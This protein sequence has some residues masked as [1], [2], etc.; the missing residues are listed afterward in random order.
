MPS[1]C[2]CISWGQASLHWVQLWF[3]VVVSMCCE[4]CFFGDGWQPHPSG[5]AGLHIKG[6]W[7]ELELRVCR[8]SLVGGRPKG[9]SLYVFVCAHGILKKWIT[10][11]RSYRLPWA[12]Q[13][14]CYEPISGPRDEQKGLCSV[15]GTDIR[16]C[17]DRP[18]QLPS[19]G[20]HFKNWTL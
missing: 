14:G 13:H 18:N 6:I 2:W 16:S 12:A 17:A 11:Y 10:W 3:S 1:R 7:P 15:P 4:G 20:G 19:S 5:K 9:L 8:W